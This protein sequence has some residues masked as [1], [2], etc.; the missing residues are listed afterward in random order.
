MSREATSETFSSY[1]GSSNES[2][3]YCDLLDVFKQQFCDNLRDEA[4]FDDHLATH[5]KPVLQS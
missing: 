2:E 4:A 1:S 3:S 5:L